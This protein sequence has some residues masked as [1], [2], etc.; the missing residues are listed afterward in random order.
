MPSL[1]IE[2]NSK[3]VF[4]II[5]YYSELNLCFVRQRGALKN[6]ISAMGDPCPLRK[7]KFLWEN[8]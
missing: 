7:C 5:K 6:Y 4:G 8:K 3:S 1:I 2:F